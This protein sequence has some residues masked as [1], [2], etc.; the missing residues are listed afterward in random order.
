MNPRNA[1]GFAIVLGAAAGVVLGAALVTS[2][3]AY[4]D[5]PPPVPVP[6][7]PLP[8][9]FFPPGVGDG[10][11]NLEQFSIPGLYF[12]Q[13]FDQPYTIYEQ[14]NPSV[15]LGTYE[16][17]ETGQTIGPGGIFPTFGDTSDKVIGE[18]TGAAPA[19]GTVWDTSSL[20][21]PINIPGQAPEELIYYQDSSVTGPAGTADVFN[22][23]LLGTTNEYYSGPAG[24]FDYLV[25]GDGAPIPIIDIPADTSA[26]AATDASTLWSD[27]AAMF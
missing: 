16:V 12:S 6:P 17:H 10:Q 25:F 14:G 8:Q 26:T 1:K 15:V 3:I 27:L 7:Y 23:G 9:F 22:L 11:T 13:Q 5:E 21:Q 2:P 18:H 24:T 4:A 19:D 20:T